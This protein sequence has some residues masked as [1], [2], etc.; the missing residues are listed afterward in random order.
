[1]PSHLESVHVPSLG[2]G[3]GIGLVLLGLAALGAA[4]PAGNQKTFSP[5]APAAPALTLGLPAC[6]HLALQ[7]QPRVGTAR[8]TLAVAQDNQRALETL[9]VP[10]FLAPDLPIRRQQAALGIVAATAGVD[11][12]E[13]E[14]VYA[15]TRTYFTVLFAQAQ[16]RVTRSVVERLSATRGQTEVT[17]PE[18]P[19]QARSAREG[20]VV[21][22]LAL[23]AC[24]PRDSV[25]SAA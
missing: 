13:R 23:R 15:V 12:A 14:A 11:Q 25:T 7:R 4:E 18:R 20:L 24:H 22:A 6:L 3:K 21:P 9:R 2:A 1:M 16:Q 10:R 8:A 19:A 5:A 17:R